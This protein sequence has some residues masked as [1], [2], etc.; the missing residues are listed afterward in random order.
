MNRVILASL[1]LLLCACGGRDPV[2]D[3]ANDA[4]TADIETLPPDE[5]ATTPANALENGVANEASA[6]TAGPIPASLQGRWAL[7]PA[8]C[9]RPVGG[10]EGGV[11]V[12]GGELRFYE[13]V[14]RPVRNIQ[15]TA[16]SISAD[17][18]FTGEGMEWSSRVALDLQDRNKLVRT[19]SN[20]AASYTYARCAT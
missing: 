9:Q 6:D 11:L 10:S 18:A 20:P 19:E 14:A 8:D 13:S 4:G 1:A 17:F 5:S 2:D 16:D 12:T 3:D 7:T 15:T